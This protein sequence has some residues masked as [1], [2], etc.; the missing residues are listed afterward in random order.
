MGRE[1]QNQAGVRRHAKGIRGM[2]GIYPRKGVLYIFCI[3]IVIVFVLILANPTSSAPH[4]N[5]SSTNS[6]D[7]E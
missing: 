1:T 5:L 3:A 4:N 6:S 2:R 7:I